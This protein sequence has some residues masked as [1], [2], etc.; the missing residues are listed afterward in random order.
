M[1]CAPA[2]RSHAPTAAA[3]T[4]SADAGE[5]RTR[6][7]LRRPDQAIALRTQGDN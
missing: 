1:T 5:L 6:P 2:H 3:P 7:A 4:L